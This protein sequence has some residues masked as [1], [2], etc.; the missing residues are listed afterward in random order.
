L[1]EHQHHWWWW[2]MKGEEEHQNSWFGVAARTTLN[3]LSSRL[4]PTSPL[5]LWS[6]NLFKD[7]GSF[8]SLYQRY[9]DAT[10]VFAIY[11]DDDANEDPSKSSVHVGSTKN[12]RF[13][14]FAKSPLEALKLKI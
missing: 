8:L 1:E 7:W 6:M 11:E 4:E 12:A 3:S 2:W 10:V 5:R 9:D 13:W 14:L